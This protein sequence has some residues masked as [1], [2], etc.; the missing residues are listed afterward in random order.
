MCVNDWRFGT[1][2]R[3]QLTSFSLA[4]AAT[5]VIPAN[6]QRLGLSIGSL[7]NSAVITFSIAVDGVPFFL[8][9]GLTPQFSHFTL[10]EHGDLPTK[11]FIL[12]GIGSTSSGGIIE[13]IAPQSYL[14]AAL[15][16]FRRQYPAVFA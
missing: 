12:T 2:I 13:Y 4:A 3:T 11:E 10:V 14:T 9:G 6:P 1:L 8:H 15:E 16:E 7:T 5:R